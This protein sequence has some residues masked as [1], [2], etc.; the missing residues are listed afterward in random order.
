MLHDVVLK[1]RH[2]TLEPLREEHAPG[3]AAA[4]DPADDVWRW[5]NTAPR[6]EAE[7][8]QW[9]VDRQQDKPS[10]KALPFVQRDPRSGRA[11]GSTSLFD[12]NEKERCAEI[13]HTWLASPFRRTGANTE[14][15]LLLLS[16]GFETLGLVRIQLVTDARNTR[17]RDAILRIGAKYEGMLRNHRRRL[18]G[19][20]RDSL[21]FSVIDREWP[22]TKAAL[23]AKL[24]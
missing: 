14:A 18:D 5:T 10:G 1:G 12:L 15:K 13:G 11:M 3:L 8:R 7:M 2:V 9:I 6:G 4:I 16:Y 24:R 19:G 17:S 23:V 20:F 21:Y 22:Q